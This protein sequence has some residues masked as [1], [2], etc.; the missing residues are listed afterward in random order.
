MSQSLDRPA[1]PFSLETGL[2]AED[3]DIARQHA[4]TCRI[5]RSGIHRG[6]RYAVL[7]P[8]GQLAHLPCIGR[9]AGISASAG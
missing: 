9:M 6:E 4:G 2:L 5:C 8:F 7:V 3:A 1:S